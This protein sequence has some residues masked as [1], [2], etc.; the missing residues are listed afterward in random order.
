M[1]TLTPHRIDNDSGV[2][3]QFTT[4]DVDGDGHTDVVVSNKKGVALLLQVRGK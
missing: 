3:T 2:G 4:Q 1:V